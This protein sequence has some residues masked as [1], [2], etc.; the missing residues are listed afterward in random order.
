MP[1]PKG[2]TKR[3]RQLWKALHGLCC[4]IEQFAAWMDVE[5]KKPSTHERGCRLATALSGV[6]LQ[7]DLAKHFVLDF[8]LDKPLKRIK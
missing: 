7:K 6:E 2:A 4:D 5:M 3:E 1:P 8:P